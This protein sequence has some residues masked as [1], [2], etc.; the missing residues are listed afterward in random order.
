MLHTDV[1]IVCP[2]GSIFDALLIGEDMACVTTHVIDGLVLGEK[3][4]GAVDSWGHLSIFP[5]RLGL[6]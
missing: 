6:E 4:N 3:L 1:D 2:G 5:F